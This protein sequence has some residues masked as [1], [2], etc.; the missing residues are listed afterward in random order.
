MFEKATYVNR[1][2]ALVER[3]DSGILVFM[4]NEN[5]GMNYKDNTYHF[6]Q[7]SNFLYFFGIDQENLIAIIDL[8]ENKTTIYGDELSVEYVVWMG[9]Q[10]TIKEKA[11]MV[12]VSQTAPYA[13]AAKVIE[14][15]KSK[16]RK[17][18]F[19]PQYRASNM[20]KLSSWLDSSVEKIKAIYSEEFVKSIVALRSI[21]SEE[22]VVEMEKALVTT[23]EMH[24]VAMKHARE[25]IKESFL[26][27]L[28]EWQATAG[29]GG[30]AYPIIL[31]VNGQTLHNHY[32]GNVLK[33]GQ[34]VLGDFGADT[35]MHYAGD[36]T[37]TF[38]VDSKFTQKQKDI[39]E[40]VLKAEI[41]CIE[42]LKP[43]IP[44]RDLHMKAARITL[45]GLKN[46]GLVK[47]SIDDA[48]TEGA[49]G[50]FFP[51]GLGHMIGL[52]VHDMEDLG[53]QY[54]GYRPGLER[55]KQFGLK[56]LRLGKELEKGN[57]LTVEP[58]IYFIPEL[59]EKWS[60]EKICEDFI[61][62]NKITDY[63][64]F[65]GIR[66]EDNCLITSQGQRTLGPPIP[67]TINEIE[68]IR[69][70]SLSQL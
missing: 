8:D 41:D 53:E 32:H 63:L 40:I 1:R 49:Y 56:S 30:L 61:N 34:L 3:M 15:A 46:L 21:K 25:G 31:T 26:T 62:Y 23:K 60:K 36:I 4:G 11:S 45:E 59:I 5:V 50:L 19:L 55:S 7:D 44:Y 37:R 57:V 10:T 67:K 33:K 39:Y 68:E 43:G 28:V 51:H 24:L 52:D 12:G 35:A 2:S 54:V 6:R 66:I 58:G 64:A 13:Q 38:P 9:P 17:V 47:G 69:Q 29:G 22:E 48:L 16:D 42:A 14:A 27:G 20:I 70:R 65:G 18:H